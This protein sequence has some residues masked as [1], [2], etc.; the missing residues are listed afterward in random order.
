M[1]QYSSVSS[2]V[3]RMKTVVA[4]DKKIRKRVQA[5]EKKANKGH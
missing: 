2:V 3:D 1:S 5:I 4:K